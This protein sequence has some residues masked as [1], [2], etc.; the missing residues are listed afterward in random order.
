MLRQV[1]RDL[2]VTQFLSHRDYLSE[3]YRLIKARGESYSY[4]KFAADLG[5][6]ATNVIRLVIAGQRPLTSKAA[7][8]IAKGLELRGDGR[9]YWTTLIKYASARL[10][11]ERDELFRLLISYKT[12]AEPAG[13]R[14][15]EAEYFGEWY[16]PVVREMT[17]LAG[18]DGQAEWIKER[19]GFSLRLEQIKRSLELLAQLGLVRR[20]PGEQ[21]YAR[22]DQQVVTRAEVDS[23]AIVRYHQKMIEI[24]RESITTVPEDQ[25]DIRAVTVTLPSELIPVLKGKIEEL[26]MEIAALEDPSRSEARGEQVV[27]VNVQMFPFTKP[28]SG[29]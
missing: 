24:G 26:V 19:L 9:R 17:A 29:G 15:I 28:A 7:E 6:S 21:R 4:L 10:P 5:F 12:R 20:V 1:A 11:A 25:R 2:P 22:T 8:K 3:L 16:H 23:L 18:F 14:P 13:L 27:Q